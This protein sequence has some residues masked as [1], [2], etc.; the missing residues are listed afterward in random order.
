MMLRSAVVLASLSGIYGDDTVTLSN[1][2]VMPLLACGVYQYNDTQAK[3][4]VVQSLTNGFSM[5]DTGAEYFNNQGVGEGVKE[6]LSSGARN[7]EDIFIQAK[8]QGCMFPNTGIWP[9]F[10]DHVGCKEDTRL[11]LERQL[12]ELGDL[13]YVDSSILHFPPLPVVAAGGCL[14]QMC[15]MIQ[16][17]WAAMVDFYKAGKTR[18]VG[19]SNYCKGCY[20]NCLKD[21]GFEVLPQIHQV[22]YHLG[23]G[24]DSQGFVTH[25]QEN[26]MTIQAYSTLASKPKFYI[27]EPRGLNPR[28]LSGDAFD[29]RLGE[30][31]T[32]HNK[33]TIQI[34][35]KWVVQQGFVALTKS[36][37][38]KHLRS[39][40]D[41]FDFELD[42][43]DLET[44]NYEVPDWPAAGKDH[45][46]HNTP[47]W[48]CHPPISPNAVV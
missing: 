15:P 36:T 18:S 23:A 5:I 27:W 45:G 37:N 22:Q 29:G 39:D 44:L 19:V 21:A 1:G 32:K 7:R 28:I 24:P 9:D 31:A 16:S 10:I 14:K 17:Q 20:D 8:I 48:A 12:T 46:L 13:D 40:V 33:S 6:V 35:L 11:A 43:E 42:D 38:P 41:L 3:E 26:N 2:V 25:A 30:I 34:A 47:A 4:A